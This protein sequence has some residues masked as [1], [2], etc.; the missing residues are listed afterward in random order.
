MAFVTNGML[1]CFFF[2][3]YGIFCEDICSH[4]FVDNFGIAGGQGSACERPYEKRG[5]DF[6]L[7]HPSS[8]FDW[9]KFDEEAYAAVLWYPNTQ[10]YACF[11]GVDMVPKRHFEY[12]PR[13]GLG[14]QPP[15]SKRSLWECGMNGPP[16]QSESLT[17]GGSATHE[18]D[19]GS[20]VF[21]RIGPFYSN[22]G[23]DWWS[24]QMRDVFHLSKVM[25]EHF[26]GVYFTSA[27]LAAASES[28]EILNLPPIHLHHIH[29][30]PQPGAPSKASAGGESS[31]FSDYMLEIHGDYECLPKDGGAKCLF[32]KPASDNVREIDR[33]VDLI[34]EINDVRAP[35]SESMKWWFQLAI[36]WHPKAIGKH[37]PESQSQFG[38][39]T[40]QHLRNYANRKLL[41]DESLPI[42]SHMPSENDPYGNLG[43][44]PQLP[45]NDSTGFSPVRNQF[46]FAVTFGLNSSEHV[47]AW[48]TAP[49]FHGGEMIRMKIHS[50]NAMFERVLLIRS[51]PHEL[52]LVGG[53]SSFPFHNAYEFTLLQDT[54]L[55]NFDDVEFYLM[56]N[57]AA[58]KHEHEKKCEPSSSVKV[59]C[60]F[61]RPFVICRALPQD[62]EVYDKNLN[63]FFSYDRRQMTCCNRWTFKTGEVSTMIGFYKPIIRPVGPWAALIPKEFPMHLGGW[64]DFKFHCPPINKKSSCRMLHSYYFSHQMRP[65][66]SSLNVMVLGDIWDYLLRLPS[67]SAPNLQE[68]GTWNF[69]CVSIMSIHRWKDGLHDGAHDFPSMIANGVYSKYIDVDEY[70]PLP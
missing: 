63:L 40:I 60:D 53:T 2:M 28:G 1:V 69:A 30:G 17:I 42:W 3:L 47:I 4:M 6:V 70:S 22:G 5:L 57:L 27:L 23:Y 20:W 14:I 54:G 10:Q 55:K 45:R 21:Q 16:D 44:G 35:A 26:D 11:N 19:G 13:G 36:R 18:E 34:A 41:N 31:Y 64:M 52:G 46:D 68:L 37:V 9:Q 56:S 25:L 38:L 39:W 59:G 43:K 66:G 49:M 61:N 29:V 33:V 7:H 48:G 65:T 62:A 50:H 51:D 67:T 8:V 15:I 32:Q 12:F 58:A 24:I